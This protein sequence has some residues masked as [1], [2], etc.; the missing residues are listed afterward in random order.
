MLITRLNQWLAHWS[1]LV[2]RKG[3]K[4]NHGFSFLALSGHTFVLKWVALMAEAI[5]CGR[6]LDESLPSEGNGFPLLPFG[7]HAITHACSLCLQS[8]LPDLDGS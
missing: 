5:L 6:Q 8:P 1:L 4:R 3:C 7:G 2:A